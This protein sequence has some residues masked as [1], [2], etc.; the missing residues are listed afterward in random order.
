M[1]RVYP[2]T[3]RF[4]PDNLLFAISATNRVCAYCDDQS[5]WAWLDAYEPIHIIGHSIFVYDFSRRPEALNRLAK[6]LDRQGNSAEAEALRRWAQT[7][8]AEKG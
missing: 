6:V 5:L 2:R 3:L 8:S 1:P 4:D 7:P